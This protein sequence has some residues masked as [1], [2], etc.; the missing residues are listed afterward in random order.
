MASQG[1]VLPADGGFKVR[2]GA[3]WGLL[4]LG[5]R[6]TP[7]RPLPLLLK[8]HPA[9]LPEPQTLQAVFHNYGQ[10]YSVEGLR[11]AAEAALVLDALAGEGVRD[12]AGQCA[13]SHLPHPCPAFPL[14]CT[15][16]VAS[17]HLPPPMPFRPAGSVPACRRR[18]AR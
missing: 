12:G 16:R 6:A 8:R 17:A 10:Q 15:P 7:V 2:E 11:T 3:R 5:A 14:S 4:P 13:A 9:P 1:E 18:P